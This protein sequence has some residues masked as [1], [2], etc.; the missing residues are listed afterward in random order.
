MIY[1]LKEINL[2]KQTIKSLKKGVKITLL[3]HTSRII[4]YFNIIH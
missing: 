1:F 3:T 4:K 2:K